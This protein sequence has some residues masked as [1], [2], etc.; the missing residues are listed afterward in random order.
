MSQHLTQQAKKL[1]ITS[2][3]THKFG[4]IAKLH[5]NNIKKQ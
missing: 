4:N 1:A 2:A 5:T 3:N